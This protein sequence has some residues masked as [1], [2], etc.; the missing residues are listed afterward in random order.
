[1]NKKKPNYIRILGC[2][3]S[4]GV[5]KID[6]S[7]GHCKKNVRNYRS[8]SSIFVSLDGLDFLID[9][10]PDIKDQF[11]K[12]KINNINFVLF[13]HAHA[14][15]IL[16]IN[17][18]RTFFVKNKK[19]INIY[20]TSQTLAN[21]KKGFKYLFINQKNYPAVLKGNIIKKKFK[22]KTK[23]NINTINVIHGEMP[24]VGY[25]INNF[26]YIPDFKIIRE[27]EIKKLKNLEILIIDCFRFKKHKTHVN[28]DESI[29]YIKNINP[30]KA[31]L[32]NMSSDIDYQNILKK[33]D[34]TN[35]KPCYDGLK[36]YI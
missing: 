5:P 9:T 10:S 8:R 33:I 17:E 13:T 14:D 22:I 20:S 1:M 36:I 12:N 6:G 29:N 24:T 2:G 31:F 18:L 30:K 28:F 34:N 26:A 7:W 35:I 19:K 16:G 11:L 25:R 27:K 32:T 21:L 15:H 3:S 23:L 4:Q